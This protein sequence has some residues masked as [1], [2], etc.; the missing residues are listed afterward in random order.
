MHQIRKPHWTE[1]LQKSPYF[2]GAFIFHLV[3]S[4]FL[5]VY[6]VIPAAPSRESDPYAVIISPLS[7]VPSLPSEELTSRENSSGEVQESGS[8]VTVPIPS[9]SPGIVQSLNTIESM[10]PD[11]WTMAKGENSMNAF[12][13]MSDGVQKEKLKSFDQEILKRDQ[14][15]QKFIE[16]WYSNPST[17]SSSRIATFT[18]YVGK[19]E[20]LN[21]KKLI[22][23]EEGVEA[24]PL[25][26]LAQIAEVW[27][28]HSMKPK[29][30]SELLNLADESLIDKAPPFVFLSG[31]QDFRL[32][33]KEVLNLQN[34]LQMGGAIWA[35]NGLAGSGSRFDIAFRREMKRVVGELEFE[36]LPIEHPL[37][38]GPKSLFQLASIP[39]GMNYRCDPIQVVK[40]DGEIGIIYTPNNY[41]DMM[42]MVFQSPLKF[43][44]NQPFFLDFLSAT[45][46]LKPRTPHRLWN[47][48]EVYFRN[49]EPESCEQVFRLAVNLIFHLLSRW[50]D[51]YGFIP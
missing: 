46:P 48:R 31:S 19:L 2:L 20:G 29:V 8:S 3:M 45:L 43:K 49:F 27:G 18:L 35:D 4:A 28:R 50:Q 30:S 51:R 33:E 42:R 17:I 47:Q 14:G 7:S 41:T 36:E 44:E 12:K 15:R 40:I 21:S 11:V 26:N 9:P 37:F 16:T 25:F 38:Q 1:S 6:V 5:A 22:S 10:K 23:N 24:G 39:E 13:S 34:Y 32:T